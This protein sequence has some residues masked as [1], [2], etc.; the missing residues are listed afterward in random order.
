MQTAYC[1]DY[2]NDHVI[3]AS[4]P[5]SILDSG[6]FMNHCIT[7]LVILDTIYTIVRRNLE[8]QYMN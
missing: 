7:T 5:L 3:M 2:K 4:R 8:I 6:L 1:V